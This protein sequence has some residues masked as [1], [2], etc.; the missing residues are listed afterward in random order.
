MS[1]PTL[2]TGRSVP[3]GAGQ[4][5][6]PRDRPAVWTVMDIIR[7]SGTYL[8]DKGIES[9]R[10][11]AEHI[12]AHVLGTERFQL[13]MNF[14]RPLTKGELAK[15]RPLLRR[16]AAREPLQ[17]VLGSAPFRNLGLRVDRRVAIPR[18]ETEYMIDVLK[19]VAGEDRVFD[20]A[21][22]V[23][24]GSGAIAVALA[25]EGLATSVIATDI[26]PAAISLARENAVAAGLSC[27]DFRLGSLLNPVS[28]LTFDLVLSNPPYLTEA[29]WLDTEPEVREWEPRLAMVARNAGL[30]V[31]RNLVKGLGGAVRPGGWVGLEV[32]S[33]QGEVVAGLLR[34]MPG[35]EDV[36]VHDDLAGR[37]R[38]VF[39]RRIV[40]GNTETG[41]AAP[42]PIARE[43]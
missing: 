38:Y 27:I 24:T 25:A 41:P 21:V 18:P 2:P 13:Y 40:G 12:L 5:P 39:A 26:S 6:A 28:G 35:F 33:T 3:P 43:E 36:G 11:N 4:P 16:R 15:Y 10:L 1:S 14:D 22:D 7:W 8:H 30:E 20:S 37:R 9:G 29:E 19:R 31:I 32:G 42:A 23:G 17:Y 34:A